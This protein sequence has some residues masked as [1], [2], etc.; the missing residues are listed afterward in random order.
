MWQFSYALYL[1][2]LP[3]IVYMIL[4]IVEILFKLLQ[5]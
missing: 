1:P 2:N 5:K 3:T 4:W